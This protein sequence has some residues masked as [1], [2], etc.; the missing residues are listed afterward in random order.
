DHNLG[1]SFESG[2]VEAFARDEGGR[3]P[4]DLRNW[5]AQERGGDGVGGRGGCERRKESAGEDQGG[6][7][8]GAYGIAGGGEGEQVVRGV[9]FGAAGKVERGAAD[10]RAVQVL[11]GRVNVP[12]PS[13]KKTREDGAPDRTS[14]WS[15]SESCCC[16]KIE[17]PP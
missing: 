14:S 17:A 16:S 6:Q 8:A 10:E 4:G 7:G 2:S 15:A 1:R 3:A 5:R 9:S 11:D 12:T 13:P